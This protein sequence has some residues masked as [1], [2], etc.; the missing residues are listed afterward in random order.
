MPKAELFAVHPA[1]AAQAV[2]E[3]LQQ[4]RLGSG[5]EGIR[6]VENEGL[7]NS[8]YAVIPRPPRIASTLAGQPNHLPF[9]FRHHR[10]IPSRIRGIEVEIRP[11]RGSRW[12]GFASEDGSVRFQAGGFLDGVL[13]DW[14][15]PPYQTE[16]L[17]DPNRRWDSVKD[18][19]GAASRVGLGLVVLP[20]LTVDTSV[21]MRLQEW[22]RETRPHSM[23]LI[24]AGSFHEP[25]PPARNV[26]RLLD[27]TGRELLAQCKL[28][29]MRVGP[30][31]APVDEG[32]E[33]GHRLVLLSTPIGLI[34]LAICLDFCDEGDSTVAEL[35]R[36][37]G[38]EVMLVPSMGS[39][40]TNHAH[41]RR[42]RELVR[43]HATVTIVASQH[44]EQNQARGLFWQPNGAEGHSEPT[45]VGAL[46]LPL[47]E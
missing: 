15:F 18:L 12:K 41:E 46:C 14:Q 17:V 29:P 47:A 11:L 31:S 4:E 5:F 44:P 42:A 45:I 3:F 27:H 23:R 30:D 35:W 38:A 9:W 32:V 2:D 40:T 24:A 43:H 21:R 33:G 19:L 22:L 34:G 20:E 37:A 6:W 10:V 36:L 13:P 8:T 39:E 16:R 28:Q 7:G 26:A 25:G 1:A